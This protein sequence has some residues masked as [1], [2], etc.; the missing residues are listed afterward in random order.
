MVYILFVVHFQLYFVSFFSGSFNFEIKILR[1]EMLN[2][3]MF[4]W[5]SA[6]LQAQ[7]VWR[8]ETKLN[9]SENCDTNLRI[10]STFICINWNDI[11]FWT[12]INYFQRYLCITFSFSISLKCWFQFNYDEIFIFCCSIYTQ[13]CQPFL[14][15]KFI[16]VPSEHWKIYL[17]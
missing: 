6:L 3:F 8:D 16:F 4:I 11:T 15:N 1:K 14:N 13:K 5:E 9:K 17:R 7:C 10:I 2:R 12:N